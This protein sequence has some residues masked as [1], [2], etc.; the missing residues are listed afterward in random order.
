MHCR[1]W[2]LDI[3][4]SATNQYQLWFGARL[5]LKDLSII[6]IITFQIIITTGQTDFKTP[7]C[8]NAKR[9]IGHIIRKQLM[10]EISAIDIWNSI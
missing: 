4:T 8:G 3:V 9:C 6:L 5:F 10:I 1:K 7:T 2:G